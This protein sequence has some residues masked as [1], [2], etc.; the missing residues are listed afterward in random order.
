ME[1]ITGS[2]L[3]TCNHIGYFNRGALVI[4]Q[5]RIAAVGP[6]EFLLKKYPNAKRT[7]YKDGFI[8][9][10]LV[11]AHCHLDRAG[12]YQRYP[13]ETETSI[14]SVAWLLEGLN[15]LSKTPA[16]VIAK[17]AEENLDHFRESGVTTLGVMSQTESIYPLVKNSGLRGIVFQEIIS[18]P[19]EG[20]QRKFEIALA[21]IDKYS[22]GNSKVQMALAPYSAYTLSRNML[23]IIAGHAKDLNLPIQLHLA[24]TFAEMEF[25]FESKG[26]IA[27][28]LFPAIGWEQLPP[29]HKKTPIQHLSDIG[30]FQ[31]DTALIGGLHLSTT[32]YRLLCRHLAKV[33]YCPSGNR[34][35]KLGELPW[36][37]LKEY[38]IAVALGT[39]TYMDAGGFNLWDEMRLAIQQAKP[40]PTAEDVL[41]MAT[42]GGARALHLDTKTGSLEV[43]KQADYIVVDLP[44]P[45]HETL[46]DVC[47]TVVTNG[48]PSQIRRVAVAGETLYGG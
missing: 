10:G 20:A 32:D 46:E 44:K 13:V 42:I 5:D 18:G 7:D 11:N 31:T 2:Y 22:N 6:E 15:Y 36:G 24:E 19:S 26:Y 14:S 21:L 27:D 4:D 28:K 43:G 29:P 3:V 48:S 30:F 8:L 37:H 41:R 40:E 12:F 33:I 45:D 34:R 39:E 16:D 17:K 38:G 25:F 9:P 1:I 35:L 23:N 47:R